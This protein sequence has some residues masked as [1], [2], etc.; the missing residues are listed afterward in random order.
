MNEST[1]CALLYNIVVSNDTH[2]THNILYLHIH[3]HTHKCNALL[4]C[5]FNI[6]LLYFNFHPLVVYARSQCTPVKQAKWCAN[7]EQRTAN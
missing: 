2:T 3:T 6:H 1:A 4:V 5:L 7:I